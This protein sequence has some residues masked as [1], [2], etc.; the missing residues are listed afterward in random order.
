MNKVL[1]TTSKERK[2]VWK[3][4]IKIF[5]VWKRVFKCVKLMLVSNLTWNF[6]EEPVGENMHHFLMLMWLGIK[7]EVTTGH[8][9]KFSNEIFKKR[10]I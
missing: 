6:S 1:F 3:S 10:K 8:F 2:K 4:E 7:F 9:S 5:P